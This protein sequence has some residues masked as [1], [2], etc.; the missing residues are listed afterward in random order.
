MGYCVH[1]NHIYCWTSFGQNTWYVQNKFLSMFLISPDIINW[2]SQNNFLIWIYPE[3]FTKISQLI[4]FYHENM[5]LYYKIWNCV[6]VKQA[7]GCCEQCSAGERYI[8]T[9]HFL[10]YYWRL[11]YTSS[12]IA[13]SFFSWKM[14]ILA[15]Y[16]FK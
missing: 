16:V 12:L 15:Q 2:N 13:V 7:S 11:Y 10:Q 1:Q 5:N 6:W 3:N 14:L 4:D 9:Y 8:F